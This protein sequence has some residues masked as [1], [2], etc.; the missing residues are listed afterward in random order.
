MKTR[1]SELL[2]RFDG[3]FGNNWGKLKEAG[4]CLSNSVRQT[5]GDLSS[6]AG[7]QLTHSKKA[8]MTAEEYVADAMRRNP[9]LFIGIGIGIAATVAAGI[10]LM[11]ARRES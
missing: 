4:A 6:K 11:R 7:D 10:I 3:F 9:A 5:A 2:H 8:I 1:T